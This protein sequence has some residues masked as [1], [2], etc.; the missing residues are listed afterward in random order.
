MANDSPNP[1]TA[2]SLWQPWASLIAH[3]AKTIETRGWATHYRGPLAIHAA[4]TTKGID[5]LPGDCEGKTEGGWVYGYVGNYQA[6]YCRKTSDEGRRGDAELVS[7][8]DGGPLGLQ[9]VDLPL[10]AVVATCRLVACVPTERVYF[11]GQ[12]GSKWIMVESPGRL[13]VH[14]QEDNRPLGDF[15]GGRYAWL[16]ANIEPLPEP[17]PA[18]GHQ[19]LWEWTPVHIRVPGGEASGPPSSDSTPPGTV[20]NARPSDAT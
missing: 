9:A 4:K 7:L 5:E 11:D 18:T 2:L 6:A 3:G 15:S 19:G 17:I 8:T 1:M 14:S 12:P 10:G 20:H 13:S 16:L